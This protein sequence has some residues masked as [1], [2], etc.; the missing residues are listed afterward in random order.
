[1]AE[2]HEDRPDEPLV[3]A[4]MPPLAVVLAWAEE[5]KGSPLTQEEVMTAR[6]E[7]PAMTLP[8][9]EAKAMEAARGFRDLDPDRLWEEWQALRQGTPDTDVP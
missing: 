1:M 2:K 4:H 3:V 7:A 6:D 5:Q 9:S 8:V